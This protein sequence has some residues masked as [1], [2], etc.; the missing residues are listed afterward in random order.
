[1]HICNFTILP[2]YGVHGHVSTQ[3]KTAST[4]NAI[5]SAS[6][7]FLLDTLPC[8]MQSSSNTGTLGNNHHISFCLLLAF[9]RYSSNTLIKH[10]KACLINMIPNLVS[11]PKQNIHYCILYQVSLMF[12]H[13]EEVQ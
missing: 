5:L 13:H 1:M 3:S 4:P 6:F 8:K 11:E 12:L 7:K 10:Y 2:M 9:K